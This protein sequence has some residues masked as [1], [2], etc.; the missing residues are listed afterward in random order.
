MLNQFLIACEPCLK[1]LLLAMTCNQLFPVILIL[2]TYALYGRDYR[3]VVLLVG[4][5]LAITMVASVRS[6]RRLRIH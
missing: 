5:V 4:T 2:R 3:V 6:C 1:R